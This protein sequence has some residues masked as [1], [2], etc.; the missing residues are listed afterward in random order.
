[1]DENEMLFNEDDLFDDEYA[2]Q[3]HEEV[4]DVI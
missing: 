4:D 1:M 3:T 2:E